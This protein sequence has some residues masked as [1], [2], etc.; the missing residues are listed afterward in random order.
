M[1]YRIL[2]DLNGNFSA[3]WQEDTAWNSIGSC[4]NSYETAL[5]KITKFK[6]FGNSTLK[7]HE[8]KEI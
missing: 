7:I 5:K 3:Q 8:I 4:A 2:E 6:D 1:K